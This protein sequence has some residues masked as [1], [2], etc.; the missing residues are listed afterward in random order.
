MPTVPFDP[1]YQSCPACSGKSVLPGEDPNYHLCGCE[2]EGRKSAY[3]VIWDEERPVL[4][5]DTV[6]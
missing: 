5:K 3:R 6:T 4:D 2:I 1:V